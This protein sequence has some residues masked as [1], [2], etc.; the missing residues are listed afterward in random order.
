MAELSYTRTE[1]ETALVP[2]FATSSSIRIELTELPLFEVYTSVGDALLVLT[3]V[4]NAFLKL[5]AILILPFYSIIYGAHPSAT[6][7][8][9]PKP[10]VEITPLADGKVNVVELD[11]KINSPV[12]V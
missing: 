2:V 4:A 3:L 11:V 1:T 6:A 7:S 12:P 5:L 8:A 9:I 10:S